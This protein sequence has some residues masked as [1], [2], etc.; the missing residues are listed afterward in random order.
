MR[1]VCVL[2]QIVSENTQDVLNLDILYM[3]F[4]VYSV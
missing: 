2:S 3:I 1:Y 4:Y